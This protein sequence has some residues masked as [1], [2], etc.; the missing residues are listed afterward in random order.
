[1]SLLQI[2]DIIWDRINKEGFG[3]V[4]MAVLEVLGVKWVWVQICQKG[5]ALGCLDG[6]LRFWFKKVVSQI[7]RQN[8]SNPAVL[9]RKR[10]ENKVQT[11]FL[12]R[13]IGGN[14]VGLRLGVYGYDCN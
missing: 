11:C 12:E 13:K 8:K 5:G 4:C 1:M 10:G 7:S 9:N 3:F 6:Q 14:N 2:P